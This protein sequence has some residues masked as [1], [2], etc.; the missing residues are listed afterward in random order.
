LNNRL[1]K[2]YTIVMPELVDG[3]IELLVASR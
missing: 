1:R 3:H 2:A